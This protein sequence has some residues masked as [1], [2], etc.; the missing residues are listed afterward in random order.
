MS[1]KKG[2]RAL[3]P[4]L[5][6]HTPWNKGLHKY[7]GG[8]FKKGSIPWNKGKKCYYMTVRNLTDNPS[9]K[10]ED[11]HTWKGGKITFRK[12]EAL[13]RDNYICQECGFTEKEIMMVDHVKP[14]SVFPELAHEITNLMTLCPNCHQRKTI[15]EKKL[16]YERKNFT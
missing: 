2:Q 12:R 7:L 9:R 8:G 1:F 14:N 15:K 6:G 5:K 13:K 16:K 3:N 11:S 4:F 10:G